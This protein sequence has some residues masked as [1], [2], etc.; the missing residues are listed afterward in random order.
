M[1]EIL[2]ELNSICS[3]KLILK[4]KK[5]HKE[6]IELIAKITQDHLKHHE[7]DHMTFNDIEALEELM[8]SIYSL[9]LH[10]I[11]EKEHEDLFIEEK[12]KK[13]I[14]KEIQKRIPHQQ[15]ELSAE[16]IEK[17][18]KQIKRLDA[19]PLPAQRTPEW[20]AFRDARITA[21]DFG[22]AVGKNPYSNK[23]QLIKKK[24]GE[25]KPFYPGPA[26]FHG[27]K[28]ED[29]AIYVYE[30]R[31]KVKVNEYGCIPH[32]TLDFIGAS[33][34]GI[35]CPTS[36]NR[37]YIGR[38]LEIKCPFSRVLDGSV[39]E[40]Y[41]LQVQ[42]QLEVCELEYCDFLQCIIKEINKTEWFENVKEDGNHNYQKNDM[43][44]GIVIEYYDTKMKKNGFIY[45]T[46]SVCENESNITPW[47][48]LNIDLILD[49]NNDF[50]AINY[51]ILKEYDCILVKRDRTLWRWLETELRQIWNEILA[52]KKTGNIV[53][54][55]DKNKD[56]DEDE[57]YD[58][59]KALSKYQFLPD[60]DDESEVK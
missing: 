53:V 38:M 31:N 43:E 26:I 49:N 50:V 60:S 21:S 19:I 54:H 56:K 37:N 13:E 47:I 46:Y 16:E 8:D 30:R 57:P 42:G 22:T 55:K 33:P 2:D 28:Y 45:S 7:C 58:A 14:F 23:T 40:H 51:W 44:K 20:H 36:E 18:H 4:T 9:I 32:P 27:V 5:K 35:C 29:V 25:S 52:Y 41:H 24:C 11:E 1:N 15:P 39:P 34:D 48:D 17:I 59:I 3:G 10:N 6:I 12:L